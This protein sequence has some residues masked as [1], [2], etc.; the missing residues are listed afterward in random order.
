M[1]VINSALGL[2]TI[3]IFGS[4]AGVA[5]FNLLEVS[6]FG[7]WVGERNPGEGTEIATGDLGG[8][9]ITR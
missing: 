7:L 5:V 3:S 1:R 9:R 4:R 6:A 2:I 8:W